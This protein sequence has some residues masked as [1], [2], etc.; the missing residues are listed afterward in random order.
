MSVLDIVHLPVGYT[1]TRAFTYEGVYK[2]GART[3]L[4]TFV[5]ATQHG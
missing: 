5:C 3:K 4:H 2:F 1:L